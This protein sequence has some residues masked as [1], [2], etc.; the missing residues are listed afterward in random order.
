MIENEQ[1]EH[2]KETMISK[3]QE[4]EALSIAI[5]LITFD[6]KTAVKILSPNSS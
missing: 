5:K 4:I 2:T 6:S 3:S 1:F